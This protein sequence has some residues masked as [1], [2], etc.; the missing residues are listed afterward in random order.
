V[1]PPTLALALPAVAVLGIACGDDSTADPE[2]PGG[3]LPDAD[4][5]VEAHDLEFD[6]DRYRLDAGDRRIAYVQKGAV[7]HTLL[8]EDIGDFELEVDG[9]RTDV[10]TVALEP[11]TYTFYCDVAGHRDAGME[12]E[13][14]VVG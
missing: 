13:V 10:G 12:A 8:I 6:R 11:G 9:S 2:L 1:R 5:V 7:P 14:V 4:L 3:G